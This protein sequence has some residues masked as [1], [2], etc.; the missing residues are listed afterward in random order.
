M[1]ARRWTVLVLEPNKYEAQIIADILRAAGVQKI[2]VATDQGA[3]M[4]LLEVYPAD[5][6]VACFDMEPLDGAGWTRA[7]RRN[8]ALPNRR[9][10]VFLTSRAFSRLVAEQCRHAGA[11]AL[12][13]KPLSSKTLM[14]TIGKVL[15]K[16]RPF[17][18]N[19]GE[20]YVGPC[21]RAGII[22]MD[23]PSKRRQADIEQGQSGNTEELKQLVSAMAAAAGAFAADVSMLDGCQAALKLIQG[24]AE[25][26]GDGPLMRGCAVF[27]LHLTTRNLRPEAMKSGVDACM[28]GLV[29][30]TELEIQ[31]T[32]QRD[33]IAEAM[34]QSVARA[35]SQR[36]AA[37]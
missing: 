22:T 27:M 4:A 3:A 23:A 37:A 13:G 28:Q 25:R 7:F 34:R 21:R 19:E 8:R 32:A 5:I 15:E 31:E 2:R 11:N 29:D 35:A 17:I 30:M 18:D 14:T 9:A 1:D 36:S 20:G 26:A 12:I 6:I 16:P 10:S 24:A 33:A